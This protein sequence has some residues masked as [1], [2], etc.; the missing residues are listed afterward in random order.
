M[1]VCVCVFVC[2]FVCAFVRVRVCMV[3]YVGVSPGV[4]SPPSPRDT[5][6]LHTHTHTQ[7]PVCDVCVRCVCVRARVPARVRDYPVSAVYGVYANT[8]DSC[9][10]EL[11]IPKAA[12][13]MHK[14]N[15]ST[16]AAPPMFCMCGL[17]LFLCYFFFPHLIDT[18]QIHLVH[19]PRAN[20]FTST[21]THT[22]THTRI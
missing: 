10:T 15:K 1:C 17:H 7:T 8:K 5:C 13:A 18:Q 22:H 16:A 2:V 19:M 11:G 3:M 4:Y 21:N 12:A 9:M 20:T 6:A 14:K